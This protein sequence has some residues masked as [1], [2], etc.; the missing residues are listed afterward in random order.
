[1]VEVS[2]RRLIQMGI[3]GMA[4]LGLGGV[5]LSLRPTVNRIPKRPLQVLDPRAYSVLAAITQRLIPKGDLFPLPHEVEVAEKVDTLLASLHPADAADFVKGLL[6]VENALVGFLLDGRTQSFTASS[7]D[8][9]D[10]ALENLRTSRLPIRRSVY[11]A[12]Y[13]MVCGAYW[14][15]PKTYAACGYGGPP[16]FGSGLANKPSRPPITRRPMEPVSPYSSEPAEVE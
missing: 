7:P 15:S 11:R 9:Q 10:R 13:G 12:I 3:G 8:R 2:R 16:E 6:L 5:G 4:L 1:M 14:S